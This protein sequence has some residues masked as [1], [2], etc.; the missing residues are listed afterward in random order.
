[1]KKATK[2]QTQFQT[3]LG[4][5]R[6]N[7]LEAILTTL[8]RYHKVKFDST[9][10][11]VF[12]L[13]VNPKRAEHN[14]KGHY[15]LVKPFMSKKRICVVSKDPVQLQLAKDCGA[16]I[17]A[18][19]DFLT[20]LAK[21]GKITFDVLLAT[22]DIIAALNPLGRILGPRKLM[23]SSK[24]GL[25]TNDLKTIITKIR[26]GYYPYQVDSGGNVRFKIGKLSQ[27][28]SNLQTN[29]M[30]IYQLVKAIKPPFVKK[31]YLKKISLNATMSPGF[32]LDLKQL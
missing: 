32:V 19:E 10:D 21:T 13:N 18:Q 17:T 4:K 15:E 24:N 23:P 30:Q 5:Q 8:K 3:A 29:F 31:Q 1:M 26:R 28:L 16:Q 25:V 7:N 12:H 9:V 6:P 11:A 2:Q 14:L 27:S 20:E 22:P